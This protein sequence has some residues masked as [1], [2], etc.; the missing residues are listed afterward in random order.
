MRWCA[1]AGDHVDHFFGIGVHVQRIRLAGLGPRFAPSVMPAAGSSL[2]FISHRSEPPGGLFLGHLVVAL[3]ADRRGRCG[4]RGATGCAAGFFSSPAST[5]AANNAATGSRTRQ[6][7]ETTTRVRRR[8]A[9]FL[10]GKGWADTVCR[11]EYH[12]PPREETS[13][14][15]LLTAPQPA[16]RTPGSAAVPAFVGAV[17]SVLVGATVVL[18]PRGGSATATPTANIQPGHAHQEHS[19]ETHAVDTRL[20]GRGRRCGR[21]AAS[22]LAHRRG[23]P[24][25]NIIL[26]MTDDQGW[27][28]VS[29]N[30]LKQIQTPNLDAM[31]AAGL[32]FDRF[33]AAASELLAHAGQRDDRPPSE[34]HGRLLARHAAAHAGDDH[35][36]GRQDGRLRHRPFRQV[37][38]QRRQPARASRSPRRRPAHPGNFGFDE[39]FSVSNYFETD[40]TF[41]RNGEPVKSTGDGSDVIV[42]EALKFIEPGREAEASRSWPWSGSAARTSRTSPCPRT[43]RRPAARPTTARSSAWTAAWARCAAGCASWAS[44]T[45]RSL[46]LQRQR[47]WLDARRR[48]PRL[49]GGL[50]GKKGE[51]WEGGIRVPGHHRVARADQAAVRHRRARRAPATSIRPSWTSLELKVPNQVQ[52]LDGISLV[53]LIDGK[54]KERPKPI[55]FWHHGGGNQHWTTARGLDRQPLQA[56]TSSAAEQVRVVRPVGRPVREERPRRRA[57]RDRRAD[58]GRAGGLAAVGA[59]RASAARITGREGPSPPPQSRGG[60]DSQRGLDTGDLRRT[61]PVR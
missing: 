40:W 12:T 53:P 14:G 50:R 56:R 20:A 39:W 32:R 34:P 24:R 37:A 4:G 59:A 36:P 11:S 61:G 25:P 58:E 45:T 57:P 5:A 28:D 21:T 22:R 26:C 42:A 15:Q 18:S 38:P 51:L 47:R 27:G 8:M 54:M 16:A 3:Y 31:A 48:R 6:L 7:R 46:V 10:C 17:V 29:Y 41:S 23:A 44:P 9:G 1:G 49:T 33:Y 13:I 35:R 2:A 43:S 55:G 19:D 60:R 52:P 30:G